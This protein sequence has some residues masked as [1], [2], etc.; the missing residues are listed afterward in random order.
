MIKF[1]NRI[2]NMEFTADV[3]RG[4][5]GTANSPDIISLAIGAPAREALPI[6]FIR[7]NTPKIMTTEGRGIE[8][9]AYGP[10]MG[11]VDLRQAIIDALLTPKGIEA[12]LENVMVVAGGLEGV[13][14]AC[15]AFLNPGDTILVESPTFVH[16]V[17]I[18]DMFEVKSIGVEMDGCGIDVVDLEEKIK[19]YNPKMIYV[20][21]TFQNPS[22]RTLITE[23]RK[24][25]AELAEKYDV[26][27]LEDDPYRDIRYSGEDLP[28]IMTFDKSNHVV[29]ANSFSKIFSPGVR[30]GY[31]V[32]SK[33][34]I[35]KYAE[36]KS[37][38]NSHSSMLPQVFAAEFFKNGFYPD[39]IKRICD[40]YRV[41]RD[42]MVECIKKYMPEGTKFSYPDGGLFTWVEIPADIDT[43]ELLKKSLADPE[44][45]VAFVAGE[46][47]FVQRDGRGKNCMRLSF[48]GIAPEKIE[49]GMKRLGKLIAK[50]IK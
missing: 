36:I 49:E 8:A 38:T 12:K 18:F 41:R 40:I 6:D 46:G 35:D 32:A 5:F 17:E 23:R 1:S 42:T 9:L 28:A 30:L 24:K 26:M 3:V 44:C 34:V 25:I 27:V 20:I 7:E 31:V 15:Q 13:Y 50:E 22:G 10:I 47:F 14:L 2:K 37:A 33:E 43:S 11:A 21:P 48:G 19:K 4:L 45:M 29:M 39:H 16:A